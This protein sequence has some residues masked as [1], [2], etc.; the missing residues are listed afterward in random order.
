ML[1]KQQKRQLTD[2]QRERIKNSPGV[3]VQK[4]ENEPGTPFYVPRIQPQEQLD[5]TADELINAEEDE[6]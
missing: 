3:V 4:R 5:I 1:K 2:E 6:E